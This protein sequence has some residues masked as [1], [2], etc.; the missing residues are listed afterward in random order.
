MTGLELVAAINGIVSLATQVPSLVQ[1]FQELI[2]L[3]KGHGDLT[4][5][6]KLELTAAL[7]S[8]AAKVAAYRPRDVVA[9]S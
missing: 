8:T 9:A 7:A 3:V 5:E 6:Q 2:A 1:S 4:A